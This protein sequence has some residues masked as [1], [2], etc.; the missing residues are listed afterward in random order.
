MARQTPPPL[1]R[2]ERQ[3]LDIIY[4]I[5]PASAAEIMAHMPD[6]PTNPAVRSILRS[7]EAKGRVRHR[8]DGPRFLYMAA[9]SRKRAR[10]GAIRH[11]VR[12][13]FDGSTERAVAAMLELD[14]KRLTPE[15][16][17]RMSKLIEEMKG[18]ERT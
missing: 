11:L 13:F 16:I 12:T 1:S 7:L 14:G 18:E 5:G 15:E 10:R 9:V 4:E 8:E 3:I 6:P 17:E 2:R